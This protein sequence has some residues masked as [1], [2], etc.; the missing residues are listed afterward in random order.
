MVNRR[1]S[2]DLAATSVTRRRFLYATGLAAVGLMSACGQA[3]GPSAPANASPS[4]SS[5]GASPAAGAS[6]GSAALLPINVLNTPG[7]NVKALDALAKSQNY[8]AMFGVQPTIQYITDATQINPALISGSSDVVVV[9]GVSPVFPAVD[10]GATF[11]IL[12]G[13]AVPPGTVVA[14]GN[15]QIKTPKDLEGKIVG[16]SSV[17][18]TPY[19]IMVA[20]FKKFGV[21][22][23]KVQFVNI[24]ATADIFKAIVAKKVDAGPLSVDFLPMMQ[25]NGL[26]S[27]SQTWVDLPDFVISGT[28]ASEQAMTKKRDTLVRLLAVYAQLYRYM[29]DPASEA[30]YDAGYVAAGGDEAGAKIQWQWWKDNK[31]L[32]TGLT[33]TDQQINYMQQLNVDLGVQKAL[34][35]INRV[36]DMSLAQDALK[37]LK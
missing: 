24:G 33:L 4:P 14:V 23:N 10:A 11:K 35:P 7:A 18:S 5:A 13:A 27:I 31:G 12:A 17:G 22:A 21:D 36:A 6:G 32:D 8:Y 28:I 9:A 3:A 30:G 25:Q 26:T 2:A 34:L 20:L 16:T 37:L 1:S 15:P 29:N 19:Q